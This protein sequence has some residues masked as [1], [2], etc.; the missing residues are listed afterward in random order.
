MPKRQPPKHLRKRLEL[1]KTTDQT[2]PSLWLGGFVSASRRWRHQATRHLHCMSFGALR[3]SPECRGHDSL[4]RGPC[5]SLQ[6]K[7]RAPKRQMDPPLC[8][9]PFNIHV[10]IAL[11]II[12]PLNNLKLTQLL[13]TTIQDGIHRRRRRRTFRRHVYSHRSLPPVHCPGKRARS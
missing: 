1:S 13:R 3:K 9:T 11:Y 8:A 2:L 7:Y 6:E 4:F 10:I 5:A 12:V